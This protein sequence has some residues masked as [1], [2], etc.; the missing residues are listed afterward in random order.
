P[1]GIGYIALHQFSDAYARFNDGRNIAETLDAA[2][3]SF[4]QGGVKGWVLDIRDNPGG[5]SQTLS[6]VAGRFLGQGNVLV[7]VDRTGATTEEPVDGH[8]FSV[9]RP[10]ALLV[11]GQSASSSDLLSATMKEYGRAHLGGQRT[12]GAV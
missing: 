12:A 1:G 10:L 11:N 6:E 9:Q 2:L 7:S 4:E 5:S 8:L 3:Q